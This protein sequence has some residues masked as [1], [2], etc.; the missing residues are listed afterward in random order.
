MRPG[1]LVPGAAFPGAGW[2][3]RFDSWAGGYDASQLQQVL[4]GPAH[5]AVVHCAR[6]H[7]VRPGR[8]LDVGCGT[9]RLAT[10]L[11]AVFTGARVVGLDL[12]AGMIRFAAAQ[13]GTGSGFVVGCAEAMPFGSGSFDLVVFTLSMAHWWDARA[14][15]GEIR[16]VMTPGAMLAAAETVPGSAARPG[17]VAA[18][19]RRPCTRAGLPSLIAASGLRIRHAEP[20]R[21]FAFAVDAVLVIAERPADPEEAVK[22]PAMIGRW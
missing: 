17:P 1:G 20:I 15:L 18:W 12:S 6:R 2:A 19:R 9:G 21:P 4:Y 16:R 7:A 22:R 3:R 14:G 10:R 13:S 11:R 8:I 5:E